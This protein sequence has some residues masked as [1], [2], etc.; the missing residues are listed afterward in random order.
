MEENY[1]GSEGPQQTLVLEKKKKK[2]QKNE[3]NYSWIF[4]VCD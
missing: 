1:V 4:L 2:L 3:D